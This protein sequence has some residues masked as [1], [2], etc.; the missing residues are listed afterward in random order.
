MLGMSFAAVPLY[1][2]FC[3]VTGYGGT[4]QVAK[5]APESVSDRVFT[6]RFDA[7]VSAGLGWQFEPEQTEIT[8]RAGEVKTVGYTVRNTRNEATTGIASYNVTPD[9][10]GAWFN[11][12][13]CFCFT[14]ITLKPGEKR[15]EEVVFF[16][17]PAVV[18]EKELASIHTVTLSY[19]FF[20]VKNPA[21]PVADAGAKAPAPA[22]LQQ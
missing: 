19:T 7:N 15:S 21:K 3:R 14:E 1:D 22:K 17:D 6:I 11:K 18:K 16:I 12:L 4:T 2:L 5:K 9:K 8:I 13:A 20:P 10:M